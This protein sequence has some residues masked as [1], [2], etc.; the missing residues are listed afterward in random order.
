MINHEAK[1]RPIRDEVMIYEGNVGP[2]KYFKDNTKGVAE[3]YECGAG[4]RGYD[5]MR[6]GDYV[7]N[8]REIGEQVSL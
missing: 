8:Y 4:I 3:D 7:E 1:V 6:V 5:D 2:L